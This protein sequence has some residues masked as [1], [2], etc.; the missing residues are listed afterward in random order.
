MRLL[1]AVVF[2]SGDSGL[3]REASAL[4]EGCSERRLDIVGDLEWVLIPAVSDVTQSLSILEDKVMS[5][6]NR[7]VMANPNHPLL[8]V[9]ETQLQAFL[10][11]IL[12]T[13]PACALSNLVSL[14]LV[15]S[16]ETLIR[17]HHRMLRNEFEAR[18][19]EYPTDAGLAL[20]KLIQYCG[21][22]QMDDE[23]YRKE[24]CK[25]S[26]NALFPLLES[27]SATDAAIARTGIGWNPR[28]D[29]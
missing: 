19:R 17:K 23:M 2:Y 25:E 21:Y 26:F 28:G 3:V 4:F 9:V 1:A 13:E 24:L 18:A 20:K 12:A 16:N 11:R 22:S 29:I 14:T 10:A 7:H 6:R 15:L 5:M 27:I 8:H